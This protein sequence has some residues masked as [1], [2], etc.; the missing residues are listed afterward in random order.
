MAV[1]IEHSS[2]YSSIETARRGLAGKPEACA[3]HDLSLLATR[4]TGRRRPSTTRQ[5][6]RRRQTMA[7]V[8][9]DGF[10]LSLDGYGAGPDQDIDHP[11]GI[12]GTELHQWLV[13]TRTFQQAL[14]GKDGGTTGIDD[15]F[16]ARGFR[17]SGPGFLK[18]Y[19][20]ARS[21]GLAGHQLERLV[22]RSST[23]SR[24]GLRLDPSCSSFHRDG[25]R[26]DV[27]LRHGR[28]PRSAGPRTRG[29]GRHG[30][31]DRR[32]AGHDPAV[33]ARGPR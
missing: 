29:R 16:A 3:R 2:N 19:V 10:T 6:S 31:A 15:D 9:V 33:S 21:W 28:H 18:E 7:R 27:P 4:M 24:A 12:G 26:H 1:P 25:G 30:C 22:G 17:M 14:F 11:L 23:V 32:R 20:R 5:A 13:P 8:R